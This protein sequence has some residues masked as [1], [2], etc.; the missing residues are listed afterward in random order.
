MSIILGYNRGYYLAHI[1]NIMPVNI[2][3]LSALIYS[4]NIVIMAF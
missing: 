2:V 3:Y 1:I 4:I